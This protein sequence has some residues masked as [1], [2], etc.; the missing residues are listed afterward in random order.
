MQFGALTAFSVMGQSQIFGGSVLM[1]NRCDL[2]R[3][4]VQSDV[5]FFFQQPVRQ[6]FDLDAVVVPYCESISGQDDFLEVVPDV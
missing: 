3:L 2:E 1:K 5:L 4:H 6:V